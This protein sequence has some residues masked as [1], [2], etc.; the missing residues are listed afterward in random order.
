MT[1]TAVTSASNGIGNTVGTV[2][3]GESNQVINKLTGSA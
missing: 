1:S 3:A 2:A